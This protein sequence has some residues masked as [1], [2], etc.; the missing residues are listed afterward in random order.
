MSDRHL[1]SW[2]CDRC[3][4]YK[5]MAIFR[6]YEIPVLIEKFL[7]HSLER[8][9]RIGMLH[10]NSSNCGSAAVLWL[11]FSWS[12]TIPIINIRLF[13]FDL[14]WMAD[15]FD[16]NSS[17][18]VIVQMQKITIELHIRILQWD[19]I[20]NECVTHPRW[21]CICIYVLHLLF[22]TVVTII[23]HISHRTW[24]HTTDS[25]FLLLMML[26]VHKQKP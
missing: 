8:R 17:M 23:T 10:S 26:P 21:V 7:M 1:G 6:L 5:H 22:F 19:K 14:E 18:G 4:L 9:Y 20:C 2:Y 15:H 11:L 24:H 3:V 12:L 16:L 13:A 25:T